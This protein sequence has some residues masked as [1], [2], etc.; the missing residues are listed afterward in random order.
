MERLLALKK[1]AN[2][3]ELAELDLQQRGS[4]ELYSGKQWGVTDLAMDAIKN[5]KMVEAAREEA[6][7]II[8]NDPT[9]AKYPHLKTRIESDQETIHFE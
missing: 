1:A 9:L 2:G 8:Q 7:V 4:G 5:I 6:R 3:F